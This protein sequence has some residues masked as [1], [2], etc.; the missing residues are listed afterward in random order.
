[1]AAGACNI[2]G[3]YDA[4]YL[5]DSAAYVTQIF[6]MFGQATGYSQSLAAGLAEEMPLSVGTVLGIGAGLF[7]LVL[8]DPAL[9]KKNRSVFVTGAF[10]FGFSALTLWMASDIFPWYPLYLAGDFIS[11]LLAKLQF[12]WRFLGP[13]TA[14]LVV[15]CCSALILLQQKRPAWVRVLLPCLLLLTVIPAG[16]LMNG[17]AVNSN[18]VYYQSLASIDTLAE[19]TGGSEYLPASLSG[20]GDSAWKLPDPSFSDGLSVQDYQKSGLRVTFTA[21]NT[22]GKD[23]TARLPLLY[24]PGYTARDASGSLLALSDT[25][26][27]LTVVLPAG[28]QGTVTVQ[29]TGFWY[30]QAADLLSGAAILFSLLWFTPLHRRLFRRPGEKVPFRA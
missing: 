18:V 22:A 10:A 11:K 13:A 8:A 30:W 16:Y 28:Y 3:K 17:V 12:A 5:A 24:Y 15:C 2:T 1:M 6:A 23:A 25:S 27:D 26:G 19:Q 14:F 29:F 21:Q 7:V 4:A 9:R 20:D